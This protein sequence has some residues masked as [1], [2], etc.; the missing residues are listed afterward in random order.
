MLD[1][2]YDVTQLAKLREKTSNY[3]PYALNKGLEVTANYL[4]TNRHLLSLYPPTSS[5][6]FIWSSE[7]QRRKVMA[8]LG[9]QPYSRTYNLMNSGIFNVNNRPGYLYVY[10]ENFASYAKWVI[11]QTTQI[12][13]M[14][15]RGWKPV[16]KVISTSDRRDDIKELFRYAVINAWNEM[17]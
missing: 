13:G 8:L 2:Q 15:A 9:G 12:I 16:N 6:P 14:I 1:L 11:G 10:Y 3:P 4:N 17:P 5:Q 7:R